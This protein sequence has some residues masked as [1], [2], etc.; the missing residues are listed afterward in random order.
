MSEASSSS[1]AAELIRSHVFD[2]MVFDQHIEDGTG[3][4]KGTDLARLARTCGSTA[5]IAGFSA[6]PMRD[7][8]LAAGCDLSWDKVISIDAIR[9]SLLR[10]IQEGGEGVETGVPDAANGVDGGSKTGDGSVNESKVRTRAMGLILWVRIHVMKYKRPIHKI[11]NES[12]MIYAQV[13]GN[14]QSEDKVVSK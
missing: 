11:Q 14:S 2:L 10:C 13:C 3:A 1:L 12:I 7:E 4:L 5:I 9:D 8:H 6:D